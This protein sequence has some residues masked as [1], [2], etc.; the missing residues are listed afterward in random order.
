MKK[1]IIFISLLC[2]VV[3]AA[4]CT[5]QKTSTTEA[6]RSVKLDTVRILSA[7]QVSTFP[8]KIKASD[9]VNLSFRIA[10]PI[11]KINVETGSFVRKG[12]TIA[13][14][15][16]RDYELQLSATEAEYKSIKAEAERVIELHKTGSVTDND[17][18]KAVYGLK[19]ITAKYDAHKNSLTD[20]QL[21][22]PFDGYIQKLFFE[23]GETVGAGMPILSMIDAE[24]PEVEINIPV[25]E[26]V[27]KDKFDNFICSV[28]IFPDRIFPL[29][30]IG[31]SQ[32]ANMNQLYTVKLK[33]LNTQRP[34]PSPG[35]TTMVTISYKQ[36]DNFLV[37]IPYSAVFER[38]GSS[39]VWIYLPEKETVTARKVIISSIN[40]DG[41]VIVSDGIEAGEIIVVAGANFLTEGEKVKRTYITLL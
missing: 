37:E 16:R 30:L 11:A 22:A 4:T 23:K 12:Q 19:Q 21:R 24:A 9:E 26:F 33:M 13:E 6:V 34:L 7:N 18:D 2:F 31:I 15:D 10:G 29:T 36:D 20:T 8:G 17:Y 32:K 39:S 38:S 5:K 25:S 3:S 27:R 14:L 35:M 1:K 41:T 40:K 28:D